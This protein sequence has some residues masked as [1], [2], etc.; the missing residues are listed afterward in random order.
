MMHR[1]QIGIC[2][3]TISGIEISA[4]FAK[5]M[6]YQDVDQS[7]IDYGLVP[8]PDAS[9]RIR[10]PIPDNY[11]SGGYVVG[12]GAAQ[13]FGRFAEKPFL[14]LLRERV[15]TATLNLGLAGA[16]PKTFLD[17]PTLIKACNR[18]AVTIVQMMSGRSVSNSYFENTNA[19][20]LRP[21][22]RSD[23]KPTSSQTA[24]QD[25]IDTHDREFVETLV[26]ETRENYVREMTEL[27]SEVRVPKI[28][29][30]FSQRLPDYTPGFT[31]AGELFGHFPQLVTTEMVERLKPLATAY[32]E[33]VT[34]HGLPQPL[35]HKLT[36]EP[37]RMDLGN[38][39]PYHNNYYPS[40]EMHA[41]A[42][43]K[44]LSPVQAMLR[45][46]GNASKALE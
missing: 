30:W 4:G 39:Y 16:G 35:L 2:L 7:I 45:N 24:Y 20:L 5:K 10:G 22:H 13:T 1:G 19:D 15:G 12:I 27:L 37:V 38:L 44:L 3:S 23:R 9:F 46:I 43:E 26:S 31:S 8:L 41:D 42:A 36:G 25:L 21:W 11:A 17:R 28:L 14:T 34:S 40:P 18:A 29:F 32:V 33:C 6:H